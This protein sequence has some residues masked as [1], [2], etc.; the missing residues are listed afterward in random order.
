MEKKAKCFRVE[1]T[2]C[3]TS[4]TYSEESGPYNNS[5]REALWTTIW[6]LVT[7]N[8]LEISNCKIVVEPTNK[9]PLLPL[10]SNEQE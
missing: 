10:I 4:E 7:K 6:G 9:D 5:S 1:M 2:D 3:I 8:G